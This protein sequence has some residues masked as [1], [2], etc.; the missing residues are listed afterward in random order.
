MK[1][2]L[3]LDECIVRLGSKYMLILPIGSPT[4][5][6]WAN[7][8]YRYPRH[9]I[10][11]SLWVIIVC[12]T[13]LIMTVTTKK[14]DIVK[15]FTLGWGH[16]P[17]TMTCD[18]YMLPLFM[19]YNLVDVKDCVDKDHMTLAENLEDVA[20]NHNVMH[21]KHSAHYRYIFWYF[22]MAIDQNFSCCRFC[23]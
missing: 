16:L 9:L 3:I 13:S 8:I 11:T 19:N 7:T 12:K 1:F 22:L 10:A 21:G 20:N 23:L 6:L 15:T 18:I 2:K 5:M 17:R 14:Q 4:P